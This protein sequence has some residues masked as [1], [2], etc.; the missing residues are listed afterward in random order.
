MNAVEPQW[1][2]S[3]SNTSICFYF[4]IVFLLVAIG[5][6]IVL[7]SDIS[8]FISS[9]GRSGLMLLFRS[10]IVLALPLVNALFLYILCSRSLLEKK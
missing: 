9:R 4:Y 10:F 8:L 2:Q 1:M 6:G 5:A 7:L 3:I